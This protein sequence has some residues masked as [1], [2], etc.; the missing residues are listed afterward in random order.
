MRVDGEYGKEYTSI[1]SYR[2]KYGMIYDR[3]VYGILNA[4]WLV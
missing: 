2:N 3:Y 4:I 1:W